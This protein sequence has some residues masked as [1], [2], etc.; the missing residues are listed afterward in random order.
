LTRVLRWHLRGAF[1]NRDGA[2]SCAARE[3]RQRFLNDAVGRRRVGLIEIEIRG[4]DHKRAVETIPLPDT[5][6][7]PLNR[8]DQAKIVEHDRR[9]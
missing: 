1:G 4:L 2:R 6:R 5:L 8:R 3:V 9:R 7:K